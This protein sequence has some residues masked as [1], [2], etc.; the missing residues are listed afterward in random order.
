VVE[1]SVRRGSDQLRLIVH[2]IEARTGQH[3]WSGT[4]ERVLT[5]ENVFAV[6]EQLA[7]DLAS[8]LVQP[9]GIVQQVTADSFRHGRPETL[10]AYR[11]T[12]GRDRHAA[13]RECLEEAV[14]RDPGYADAWALLAYSYLDEYRFGY[15]PRPYDRAALAQAVTT[16]RRAVELDRD[17][18]LPLLALSTMHFHRREFDEADEVNRRLLT[19]HSTNPEVLAQVGWRIACARDWEEG[20]ALVRRAIDRSIK[21]PWWHHVFIAL[22]HYRRGDYHA[23]LAEADPIAGTGLSSVAVILAAI[24]GQLGHQDEA[25]RALDRARALNPTFLKDP[26]VGWRRS[27][28]PEDLIDQ[29]L[30]GLTKA[31]FGAFPAIN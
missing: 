24:H 30:D 22:D 12:L 6:Q 27:N 16:A 23:A 29:L 15:S 21:A 26:R 1:G 2:L 13:S 18:M 17:G 11:R 9:Y 28:I 25:Q 10:F 14:R 31:G 20:I 4:Y 8:Q 3:L 7:A 5:P 19:L